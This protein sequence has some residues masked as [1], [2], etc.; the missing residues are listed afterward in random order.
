MLPVSSARRP[1]VTAG[2]SAVSQWAE[3][4]GTSVGKLALDAL[5]KGGKDATAF[6][7]TLRT[8]ELFARV[9]NVGYQFAFELKVIDRQLYNFDP[10]LPIDETNT[11]ELKSRITYLQVGPLA[12][13]TNPGE[14]H[15]ELW[16]GGYD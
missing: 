5:S 9:D 11:P 16:V 6:D 3:A 15:P 2:P 12:L 14:L 8:Q 7:I 10:T 13:I 1:S 4:V